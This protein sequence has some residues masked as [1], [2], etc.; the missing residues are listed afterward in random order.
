MPKYHD[1]GRNVVQG[2][3]EPRPK[4][5]RQI[6]RFGASGALTGAKAPLSGTLL[7]KQAICRSQFAA[8]Y[9]SMT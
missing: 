7:P 4:G 8:I 2:A 6:A 1:R 3:K 9:E 5:G